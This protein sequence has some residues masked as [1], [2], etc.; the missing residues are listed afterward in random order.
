MAAIRV[1]LCGVAV[2]CALSWAASAFGAY[3]PSLLVGETSSALGGSGSVRIFVQVRDDDDATGMI[4][5]YSPRGYTVKLDHPAETE[6]G[7]VIAFVRTG[8]LS[9]PRVSVQGAVKADNPANHVS[10]SCA[11]GVHDAVWRVEFTLAT[12]T[13]RLPIYVDRVTTGPETAHASARMRL[14]PASPHVAQP[15]AV[16]LTYADLTVEDVFTNPEQQGT[17]AWNGVFVPYTPGTAALNTTL[18]AQS[19]AY[20]GLPGTFVVTARRQKRGKLTFALITA[21]LREAGQAVRGIRVTLYYGGQTVFSSKRVARPLTNARG[22]ATARIRIR[23]LMI[24][25]ASAR[26]PIRGAPACAPLLAPRC[27]GASTYPPSGRFRPVRIR[28]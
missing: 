17:Y 14:C 11:P 16:S 2:L 25:F 28:R 26:V 8:S 21:C 7:S 19:T 6:L 15:Q 27:T 12:T 24:A 20:I 10:N 23:K 5:L 4:T 9:G 18:T 1:L 3:T 22:C 13:Y